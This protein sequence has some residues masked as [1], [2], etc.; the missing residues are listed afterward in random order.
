[1]FPT[2]ENY[3]EQFYKF[4][5]T[6]QD[7][8]TLVYYDGDPELVKIAEK[9]NNRIT[10]KPYKA[11]AHSVADGKTVVHFNGKDYPLNIFGGHNLQNLNGARL[12]CNELGIGDEE[13]LSAM[14]SFTGAAKRLQLLE[15]VDSSNIWL[16][17][18]HSPSKLKATTEAVKSQFPERELIACMELHTFS[19]LNKKFLPHYK[20]TMD[21]ADK[22]FVFFNPEVLEHKK[23][24][25][26][27]EEEV[28]GAFGHPD[29]KVFTDSKKLVEELKNI[30]WKDRNLL[31]MTSGN[32]SG[33]DIKELAKE[34]LKAKV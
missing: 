6:I 27:S 8:G 31:I 12:I 23:L 2:W 18:A 13:F 21:A 11:I 7:N 30:E 22:A 3:L 17:F 4:A 1:V 24:P 15:S 9:Q 33:V 16:D 34:L 25:P 28:A 32:F 10:T 20:G 19:S 29:L 26:I 5:A 14:Q